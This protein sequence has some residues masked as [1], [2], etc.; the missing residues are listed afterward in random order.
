MK[1]V[2]DQNLEK[3]ANQLLEEEEDIPEIGAGITCISS[4]SQKSVNNYNDNINNNNN[5]NNKP[6]DY[7]QN[8]IQ[9]NKNINSNKNYQ[10]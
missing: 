6:N 2:I 8:R 9:E 7:T 4:V 5:I 3:N 10:K 1:Y